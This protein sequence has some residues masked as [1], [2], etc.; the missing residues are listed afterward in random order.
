MHYL[1]K[2][3]LRLIKKISNIEFRKLSILTLLILVIGWLG[4]AAFREA[5]RNL[6]IKKEAN[7]LGQEIKSLEERNKELAQTIESF[8]NEEVIEKEAR[9]RLNL[10]KPGEK[11]VVIVSPENQ[12]LGGSGA[13]KIDEN[14]IEEQKDNKEK[15]NLEKWWNYF[16]VKLDKNK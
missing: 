3:I 9:E 12:G 8:K 15:S 16:F 1:S 11:L 14:N 7:R 6:E 4:V 2:F 13:E 5:K 10:R